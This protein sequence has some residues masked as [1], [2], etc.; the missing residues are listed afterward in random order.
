M[1]VKRRAWISTIAALIMTQVVPIHAA[2]TQEDD[3]FHRLVFGIEV[4]VVASE[5]IK[6]PGVL[7]EVDQVQTALVSASTALSKLEENENARA[8][9]RASTSAQATAAEFFD[10]SLSRVASLVQS[11]DTIVAQVDAM[12]EFASMAGDGLNAARA[13]LLQARDATP[14]PAYQAALTAADDAILQTDA[15]RVELQEAAARE[16]ASLGDDESSLAASYENIRLAASVAAA[17]KRLDEPL[18]NVVHRSRRSVV[19]GVDARQGA[20]ATG[21]AVLESVG[22]VV[23]AAADFRTSLAEALLKADEARS[24][25]LESGA[26]TTD[27]DSAIIELTNLDGATSDHIRTVQ[28]IADMLTQ[29]TAATTNRNDA[30]ATFEALANSE[31]VARSSLAAMDVVIP[32]PRTLL[33]EA[34]MDVNELVNSVDETR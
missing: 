25:A 31:A 15:A 26:P 6:L 5:E 20:A 21:S 22:D 27:V 24:R 28:D 17:E 10:A 34:L 4:P 3:W 30:V 29:A 1:R 18:L 33:Q 16:S 23:T 19:D 14:D 8:L 13:S 7:K 11:V 32:D 2:E 12:Q 9:N